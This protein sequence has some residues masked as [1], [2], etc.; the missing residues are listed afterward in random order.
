MWLLVAEAIV[1]YA[2]KEVVDR[3]M[4]D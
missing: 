4:K 3:L 1:A 2:T